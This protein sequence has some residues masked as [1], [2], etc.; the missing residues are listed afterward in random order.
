T[1]RLLGQPAGLEPHAAGAERAVVDHGFR[2]VYDGFAHW[3]ISLSVFT[4]EPGIGIPPPGA[5]PVHLPRRSSARVTPLRQGRSSIE[6]D[7]RV[8]AT[9]TEDRLRRVLE[10]CALLPGL[11]AEGELRAHP[12]LPFS[13]SSAQAETLDQR[14][15]ARD[16]NS[17]EVVE[18]PATATDQ[19]QQTA[20]RVVVVLVLLQ[21]LR[22]ARD[23][24]RQQ[25]DLGLRGAGVGL[26]QA[27]LGQNRL[28][29]VGGQRH[30]CS[31]QLR[32][33]SEI[34]RIRP[35]RT[36]AESS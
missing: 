10:R 22:Q 30:S 5:A 16:V 26:V 7:G 4:A 18:Q 1:A 19:Q 32:T 13:V 31:P 11:C 3:V 36:A 35:P 23:A 34:V 28:F 2:L 21:V 6:V 17:L 8:P 25:R 14:P 9:T 12:A 27:V 20:P 15:V 24:L 33:V 29:L